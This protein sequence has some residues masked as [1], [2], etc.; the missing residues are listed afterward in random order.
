MEPFSVFPYT[1]R[2][3]FYPE[4]MSFY[5]LSALT[6]RKQQLISSKIDL[7]LML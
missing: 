4:S 2:A 7:E 1:W 3:P 6:N 5:V